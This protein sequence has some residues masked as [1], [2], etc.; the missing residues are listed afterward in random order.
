MPV[1]VGDKLWLF[2]TGLNDGIYYT[3][4]NG[5]NWDNKWHQIPGG[6]Y[7]LWEVSPV[8]NPRN[9]PDHRVPPVL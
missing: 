1:V 7:S 8:Y 9:R 5:T 4:Y 6:T 2:I 3:I